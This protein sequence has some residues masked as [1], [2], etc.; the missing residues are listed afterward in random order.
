[1]H[2]ARL[3]GIRRRVLIEV[4]RSDEG[5]RRRLGDQLCR[6]VAGCPADASDLEIDRLAIVT[7][8]HRTATAIVRR[9]GLQLV[10]DV[11]AHGSFATMSEL[12]QSAEALLVLVPTLTSTTPEAEPVSSFSPL[13]V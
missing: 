5:R 13:I 4:G 7:R 2:D 10:L 11:R 3:H 6:V 9:R 12:P 8:A 1:R